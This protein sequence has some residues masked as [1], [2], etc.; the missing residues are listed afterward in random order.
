MLI[1]ELDLLT[2]RKETKERHVSQDTRQ[3]RHASATVFKED[4]TSKLKLVKHIPQKK[5]KN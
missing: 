3:P 4:F 2:E 1:L 5:L